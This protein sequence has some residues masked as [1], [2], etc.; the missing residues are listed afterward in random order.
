MATVPA[1][2]TLSIGMPVYNGAK[3]L[4]YTLE[5]L[6]KQEFEDVEVLISD[7]AS[8]DETAEIARAAAAQDPRIRFVAQAEN[9]GPAENFNYVFRHTR[10]EFFTWLACDDVFDPVYHRRMVELLRSRPEAAAAM[11]RVRLVDHEN[12]LMEYADEEPNDGDDPDPIERFI[13]YASFSH[14]C[15]YTY[16]VSR[17]TAM[18]NTRLLLPFWSSDRLWCAELALEGPLLRDPDNLF[19]VRQHPERLTRRMGRRERATQSFY[20]TPDGSR[21]V[22]LYYAKQLR[23]SIER[24]HLSDADKARGRRA[25]RAW[26]LRNSSKLVRSAGR[27]TL[28]TVAKPF[29]GLRGK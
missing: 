19:F 17:R 11:C 9:L 7:N 12:N 22:T 24:S 5:C 8:T 26:S 10:G 18:A 15:Q 28:E 13:R 16:G 4:E 25:L 27:A 2:P 1:A 14:W 29:S 3:Y 21:A 23:E 20:L 6:R